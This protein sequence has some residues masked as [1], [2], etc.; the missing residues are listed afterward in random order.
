MTGHIFLYGNVGTRVG[1]ISAKTI[2][3]QF[4]P[5]YSNYILHVVSGGGDVFEGYAIYNALKNLNKP[6]EGHIE[7]L[8]ASIA[9]LCISAC[10]RIVM[11]RTGQFM[12]HNPQI[13]DLK[14]DSRILRNVAD[15]LDQIKTLLI[16]RWRKRT[17]RTNLSDDKLWQLYDNETWLTADEA[18]QYGF[19][20]EVVDSIKAVASIN[21][22]KFKNEME[23]KKNSVVQWIV[24]FFRSNKI[25]NEVMETLEDGTQI[26]IM[27][28]GDDWQGKQV[29]KDTGEPLPPGEYKIMTGQTISVDENSIITQITE[30]PEPEAVTEPETP[31]ENQPTTEEM[32]QIEALKKQLAEANAK[33]Q[34]AETARAQAVTTT[35]KIENKFT[36]LSDKL[37]NLEA[38][39]SKTVGDTT[40]PPKNPRVSNLIGDAKDFGYDPMGEEALKYFK[41]TNRIMQ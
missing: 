7:G 24:N 32:E 40:T 21:L 39:I 9:T 4:N 14:G 38:K 28:D 11:N 31:V 15:Q 5:A 19:V 23:T 22:D 20:D 17:R 35:A 3:D 36:E 41:S 2:R 10:D 27:A 6:I 26:M 34:E 18:E 12:I 25:T 1:E 16:D 13:S 29:W 33:L 30:A 8:C 37:K